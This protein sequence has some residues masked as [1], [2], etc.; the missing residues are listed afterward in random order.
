MNEG[1]IYREHFQQLWIY[2]FHDLRQTQLSQ[3]SSRDKTKSTCLTSAGNTFSPRALIR[4]S[5]SLAA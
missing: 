1:V 4:L 2:T 5:A 3:V